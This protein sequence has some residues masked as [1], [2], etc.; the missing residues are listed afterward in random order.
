MRRHPTSRKQRQIALLVIGGL[1]ASLIWI[2]A[3][4]SSEAE[5]G[6]WWG[7]LA[8]FCIGVG[9]TAFIGLPLLYIVDLWFNFIGR[10]IVGGAL[11]G[12]VFW[13]LMD[14]PI[15]PKDWNKLVTRWFWLDHAPRRVAIFVAFGIIV[16]TLYTAI[17]F[18]IG[19]VVEMKRATR[20][21]E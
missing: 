21:R 7:L 16:G 20:S 14:A 11:Y 10:Y 3:L 19:K 15:F 4:I 2:P 6:E 18:I 12:L 1:A 9:V 13:I 5:P 17:L 8:F